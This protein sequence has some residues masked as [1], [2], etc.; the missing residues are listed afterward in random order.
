MYDSTNNKECSICIA[1]KV[2]APTINPTISNPAPFVLIPDD[3]KKSR[4][5]ESVIL[6]LLTLGC[7]KTQNFF[8]GAIEICCEIANLMESRQ[9]SGNLGKSPKLGVGTTF[10][11]SARR[12][13]RKASPV[14]I[15][16]CKHYQIAFSR[17]IRH[18]L[19]SVIA[20]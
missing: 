13:R 9:I 8:E 5:K 20:K 11:V 7:P 15:L 17:Q 4:I 12:K 2:A 18:N 14:K 16:G 6:S 1:W 3:P 10:S 19:A